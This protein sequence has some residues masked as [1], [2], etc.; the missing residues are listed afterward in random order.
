MGAAVATLTN[1]TLTSPVIN[2]AASST[3]AANGNMTFE[4]TSDTSLTLKVKG[5]D[6]VVRSSV[7][8]LS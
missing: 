8:T 5:S 3:P 7:L 6:G 2:P 1:K 4:L